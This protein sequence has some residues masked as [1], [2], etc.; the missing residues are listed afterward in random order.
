MVS[1]TQASSIAGVALGWCPVKNN[2]AGNY[3]NVALHQ[4]SFFQIFFY[5]IHC[6]FHR[7]IVF[8]INVSLGMNNEQRDPESFAVLDNRHIDSSETLH[9]IQ[10]VNIR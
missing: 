4:P 8:D 10:S 2:A 7:I 3:E 6:H 5:V 9:V 1:I